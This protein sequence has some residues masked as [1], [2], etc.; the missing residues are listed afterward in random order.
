MAIV[1]GYLAAAG[2]WGAL[3][4]LSLGYGAI[5]FL[6]FARS[7]QRDAPRARMLVILGLVLIAIGVA[8]LIAFP[9][10]VRLVQR[11]P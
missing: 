2:S 11:D 1:A 9:E 3:G 10:S 4:L 5:F 6:L 8:L 7:A